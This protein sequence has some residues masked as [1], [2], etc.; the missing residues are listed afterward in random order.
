[1]LKLDRLEVEGFGPFADPQVIDFPGGPGVTVIYGENMRGKTSLLN[2]VR[3]AFFG[4]V[5]GRGSRQRRLHT[6]SNRALAADGQFGFHV[7]LTFEFDDAEYEL[8]RTCVPSK[9]VPTSDADYDVDVMLRRG[10]VVLGPQEREAALQQIF[11]REISRFFLFDGELLQEYEELLINESEAGRRISEAIER[12]LGVPILKSGRAHLTQ[13]S[14]R[15]DKAAA[16]EASRHQETEAL[17]NALQ[18]ATAQKEAHQKEVRRLEEQLV[19]FSAQRQELEQYLQSVQKYSV[20]LQE[21]DDVEERLGEAGRDLK[22]ARIELKHLMVQGW[23]TVLREPVRR[24]LDAAHQTAQEALDAFRYKLR[25]EALAAGHCDICGQDLPL[26]VRE[27]IETTLVTSD[28]ADE[29]SDNDVSVAMSRLRDLNSFDDADI[30]GELRQLWKQIRG[31]QSDSALLKDRLTD[32]KAALADSDP[33]TLR[34]SKAS[35]SEVMEKIAAVKGAVEEEGKKV[36]EMDE[37][38]QRL[39]KKLEA[40]GT[41]NLRSVQRRAS[42][43]RGASEVFSAAVDDYKAQLRDRVE[44]TASHLFLTMTTEEED[45]AGLSINES[46]GLKSGT[47]RT[48][49]GGKVSRGRTRGCVGIDGCSPAER[50]ASWADRNGLSLRAPGRGTYREGHQRSARNG[51]ASGIAGL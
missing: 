48:C 33:E 39:K 45:Y 24:A 2:A 3:F 27:R 20:L 51:G 30:T 1:M 40:T 9:E 19:G 36:S 22:S 7:S 28:R 37:N 16:K 13:L 4:T 50:T 41:S 26:V 32:L 8:V 31:L 6:I 17:G 38:I 35:Y 42:V 47:G 12:I 18:Q 10:G 43:L 44:D 23:R 34:R 14:E 25:A 46:Y 29:E 15:A 5:L 11:P 21:R 49:G